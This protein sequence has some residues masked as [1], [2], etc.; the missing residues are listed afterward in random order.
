MAST[1]WPSAA[2]RSEGRA[3][4]AAATGVAG[5]A[6]GQ[7]GRVAVERGPD[8]PDGLGLGRVEPV[9]EGERPVPVV[10]RQQA[11]QTAPRGLDPGG[12]RVA[13]LGQGRL[14]PVAGGVAVAGLPGRV[15]GAG[16][17]TGGRRDVLVEPLAQDVLGQGAGE[18]GRD[19]AVLRTA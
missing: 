10:E 8:R 4:R 3:A 1:R 12:G 11:R 18:L 19:H 17:P 2:S 5:A 7:G 14:E 15:G 6:L 13:L 9:D 16:S